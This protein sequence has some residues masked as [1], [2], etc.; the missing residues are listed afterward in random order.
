[1]LLPKR[2][3]KHRDNHRHGGRVDAIVFMACLL[4]ACATTTAP[5]TSAQSQLSDN[6]GSSGQDNVEIIA[7]VQG[8]LND[9][10][11]NEISGL[12][13]SQILPDR[14]WAINDSGNRAQLFA[15]T[16]SAQLQA[17]YDINVPNRDWE[18]LGSTSLNGVA[19]LLVA[20]VGDNLQRYAESRIHFIKEP[21]QSATEA[22]V[23]TG[24][25]LTPAFS[26][27][28]RFPNGSSNV[29]AMAITNQQLL[30][31]TKERLPPDQSVTP[32]RIYRLPL[33]PLVNFPDTN[34]TDTL[35][36]DSENTLVAEFI[37]QLRL[38][39]RGLKVGLLTKLLNIDPLQPTDLVI[40]TQGTE[41]YVLNYLQVLNYSRSGNETWSDAF[42]KPPRVIHNH[43]LRQAEALTVTPDDWVYITSERDGAP[44]IAIRGSNA[45]KA[46]R[47]SP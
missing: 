35:G 39:E 10:R 40:N 37:G 31:I 41:A 30:L 6:S 26:L 22:S 8:R 13:V 20:D 5:N 19:Y 1:M 25:S 7:G 24:T 29:E 46:S 14:L 36:S 11:M 28:F 38:P 21:G 45:N 9:P 3:N 43:G 44:L 23:D 18:A 4:S 47:V 27:T 2:L 15:I 33:P 12:A 34:A 17:V 42:A 16:L 32:S